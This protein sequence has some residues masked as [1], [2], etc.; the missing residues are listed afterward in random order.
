[1]PLTF[2]E[3]NKLATKKDIDNLVTKE[4]FEARLS[5]TKNEILTAI[6]G[7]AKAVRDAQTD[8]TA[9]LG[10]HD[11]LQTTIDNHE[12]RIQQLETNLA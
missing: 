10:A 9:D 11:R 1:M 5:E 3:F 4:E 8:Q 6:D 12:V 2:E 7:L